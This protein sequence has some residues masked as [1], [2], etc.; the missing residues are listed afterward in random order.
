MISP[1][2]A[3]CAVTRADMRDFVRHHACEF[4]FLIGVENQAA[5][6]V[7][8]AAW[9]RKRVHHVRINHLNREWHARIGVPHQILSYAV[10]VFHHHR[11][12]NEFCGAVH[13]LREL[14]AQRDLVLERVEVEPLANVAIANRIHIVDAAGLDVD[15]LLGGQRR[16]GGRRLVLRLALRSLLSRHRRRRLNR[17]LL[18][19]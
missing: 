7:E 6:D 15:R 2:V 5:I 9:Q 8:K 19:R 16:F 13:L 18:L 4:R 1:L 17:G 14:F 10:D 11:I 3:C 12:I